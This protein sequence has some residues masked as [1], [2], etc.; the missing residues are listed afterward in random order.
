MLTAYETNK[1]RLI[2]DMARRGLAHEVSREDKQWVLDIAAREGSS[3]PAPAAAM[4]LREGYNISHITN[5]SN[6]TV[7]V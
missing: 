7:A 2:K 1:M 4:A 3:V 5:I 6:Q